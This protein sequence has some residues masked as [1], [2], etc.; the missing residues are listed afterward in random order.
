MGTSFIAFNLNKGQR[1]GKPLVNPVKSRWFNTVAFRQAVAYGINRQAMINNISRGLGALQDSPMIVQS[2]YYLSPKEGLKAY[3]YNPEKSKELLKGAGFK[4]DSKGQL[5]DAQ[6]NRVRFTLLTNSGGRAEFVGS[7][8]KQD[9]SKIGMQVDFQAIAFNV[10]V[11]KLSNT[12]DWDCYYGGITGGS[13]E[14]NSGANTWSPDGGLHIFN[15]KPQPGQPPIEG[16]EVADWEEKIGQLY[17][18]GAQELDEAKRKAI[19]V[20]TQRL[21]QEYVPFIYLVNPLSLAAVRDR[22]Q[23]IKY[24]AIGG[25]LWNVYELK[26]VDQ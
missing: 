22:I 25:T 12:L 24:S 7:Q 20:E 16:R 4:Y 2:P 13:V 9:L 14:P 5:F 18:Q 21:A 17:I 15:Q 23:G 11:D 1:N 19:Y 26:A 8:V 6:G 10:L 3:D